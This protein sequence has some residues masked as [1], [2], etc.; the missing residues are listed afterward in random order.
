MGLDDDHCV[1]LLTTDSTSID[2]WRK[3]AL[4]LVEN[5]PTC[6]GLPD[7]LSTSVTL[8]KPRAEIDAELHV[9]FQAE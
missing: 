9:R 6:Y 7:T 3:Q 2:S 1:S 4:S 8:V 5:S